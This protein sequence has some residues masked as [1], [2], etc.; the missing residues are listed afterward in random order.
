MF[1]S[2]LFLQQFQFLVLYVP[3][4]VFSR[5]DAGMKLPS[6]QHM[7]QIILPQPHSGAVQSFIPFFNSSMPSPFTAEI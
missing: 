1:Y 3:H 7:V 5:F 6:L 4:L 2:C